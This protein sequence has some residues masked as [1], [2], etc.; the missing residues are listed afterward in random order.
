MGRAVGGR[1]LGS[2]LFRSTSSASSASSTL[3]A[4]SAPSAAHFAAFPSASAPASAAAAPALPA[5]SHL[6]QFDQLSLALGVEVEP[7]LG[8]RMLGSVLSTL[9]A[10]DQAHYTVRMDAASA[11]MAVSSERRR[12]SID[13][14]SPLNGLAGLAGGTGLGGGGLGGAHGSWGSGNKS[15][16]GPANPREAGGRAP[17]AGGAV[18]RW[19][20]ARLKYLPTA[21]PA[22][23]SIDTGG[24]GGAADGPLSPAGRSSGSFTAARANGGGGGGGS[25]SPAPQRDSRLGLDMV[26]GVLRSV[27][28]DSRVLRG[29]LLPGRRKEYVLLAGASTNGGAGGGGGRQQQRPSLV[30]AA[31][32]VTERLAGGGGGGGS[33]SFARSSWGPGG[34]GGSISGAQQSML[35]P[36]RPASPL[37]SPGAASPGAASPGGGGWSSG[38]LTPTGAASAG[39]PAKATPRG[40]LELPLLG[41]R[42]RTVLGFGSG[43]GGGTGAGAAADGSAGSG[44]GSPKGAGGG[45]GGPLGN[46]A[47]GSAGADAGAAGGDPWDTVELLVL[48]P[49]PRLTAALATL[50]ERQLEHQHASQPLLLGGP[51]LAGGAGGRKTNTNF[52]LE[53]HHS[54]IY[55]RKSPPDILRLLQALHTTL[56]VKSRG[57]SGST[58]PST[59]EYAAW[60]G[61]AQHHAGPDMGVSVV[62]RSRHAPGMSASGSSRNSADGPHRPGSSAATGGLSSGGGAGGSSR[63]VR[64]SVD[65]GRVGGWSTGAVAAL[66]HHGPS[67]SMGLPH[68]QLERLFP[69]WHLHVVELSSQAM[70]DEL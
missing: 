29:L 43:A 31:G 28:T 25:P 23:P 1:A 69:G 70:L 67:Y 13:A 21:A 64:G 59:S 56:P 52:A 37:T 41:S 3:F 10:M 58:A 44:G 18:V 17:G 34:S 24:G 33:G 30:V 6:G 51:A 12:A 2:S 7:G 47:N 9:A 27:A 60:A 46:A 62:A 48:V 19:R 57:S 5:S 39:G 38:P 45:G 53:P 63:P 4:S 68:S 40:A 26:D 49:A 22:L 14:M 42:I 55:I 15:I 20:Q 32:E 35:S 65:M 16:I 50:I 36:L 66:P 61:P 8:S 11:A 54:T